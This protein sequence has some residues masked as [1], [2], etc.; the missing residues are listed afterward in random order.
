MDGGLRLLVRQDCHL[1]EDA[2]GLLRGMGVP[3]ATVDVDSDPGLVRAY[4]DAVP[5]LL[6]GDREVARAPIS[7]AALK[8][9]LQAAGYHLSGSA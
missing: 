7:G 2:A 3:F 5:V 9:A 4:G 8:R 1:C 6:Y